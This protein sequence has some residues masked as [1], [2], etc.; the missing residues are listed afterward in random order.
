M[1]LQN[2]RTALA[3]S[4]TALSLLAAAAAITR[5][6]YSAFGMYSVLCIVLNIPL[7]AWVLW[8]SQARYR[9]KAGLRQ[10]R[11][12]RGG[13]AAFS[14]TVMTVTVG[15]TQFVALVVR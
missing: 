3:W 11:V 10:R 12:G 2:E 14:L 6:T 4:R 8:V 15:L 13:A 9:H 7:A 5:V 1:G